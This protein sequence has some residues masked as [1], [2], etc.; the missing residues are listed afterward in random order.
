MRNAAYRL[1]H[2]VILA[3][4]N[5]RNPNREEWD[6]FLAIVASVRDLIGGDGARFRQLI[7]S[8]GGSPSVRQR[9]A[10]IELARG[11]RN[12]AQVRVAIITRSA[13]ARASAT[14]FRWLGFP[15]RSFDPAEL[16]E[17]YAFLGV[18]PAE[19]ADLCAA[20]L[21]LCA[22]V[23]GP[24]RC[25]SRVEEYLSQLGAGAGAMPDGTPS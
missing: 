13:V 14:A 23:D 19:A 17:A 9:L 6:G 24:I 3:V 2:G 7:F 15:L 10:V 22:T 1:V 25:A 8:D 18:S 20:L 16:A 11:H 5:E 21:E 12:F 4:N